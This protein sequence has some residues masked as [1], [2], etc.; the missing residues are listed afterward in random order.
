MYSVVADRFELQFNEFSLDCFCPRVFHAL[1]VSACR[2]IVAVRAKVVVAFVKPCLGFCAWLSAMG[3]E[4]PYM[5]NAPHWKRIPPS[6]IQPKECGRSVAV[7]TNVPEQVQQDQR[8]EK[9]CW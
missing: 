4:R 1:G 5:G 7:E 8:E 2:V 3:A 9:Q 6:E